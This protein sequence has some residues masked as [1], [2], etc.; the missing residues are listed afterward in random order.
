MKALIH[1]LQVN[2]SISKNEA[3]CVAERMVHLV[4]QKLALGEP[5]SLGPMRL[6]KA[7]LGP[8]KVRSNFKDAVD[9]K[10]LWIG[11]RVWWKVEI[12]KAW[13]KNVRPSWSKYR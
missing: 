6:E 4:Q 11:E 7:K 5:F 1:D 13:Q 2:C 10:V 3:K 8:R 9:K 12:S